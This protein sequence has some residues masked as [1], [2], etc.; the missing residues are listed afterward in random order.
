MT[1]GTSRIYDWLNDRLSLSSLAEFASHKTVP[2]HRYSVIYYFGGMYEYEQR[3]GI[4]PWLP[5]VA[6]LTTMSVLASAAVA[7]EGRPV[8][9]EAMAS[10]RASTMG[11]VLRAAGLAACRRS[12]GR[13]SAGPTA[14]SA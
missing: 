12:A 8:S 4:P 11:R 10:G 14:G 7:L 13:R 2:M 6:L 5:K 9:S 1:T 3:L